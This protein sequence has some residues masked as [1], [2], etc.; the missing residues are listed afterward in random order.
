MHALNNYLG[1]PY[2]DQDACRRAA[3]AVVTALS[4]AGNGDVCRRAARAEVTALSGAGDGDAE[5][6]GNHIDPATGFLS[7][8]VINVLGAGVLGIHV[9]GDAVCWASLQTVE[10]GA[11]LVNWNNQHWTVLQTEPCSG[12]WIHTNSI[13]RGGPHHGR[14]RCD[15]VEDVEHILKRIEH[16]YGGVALHRIIRAVANVGPHYLESEG[17]RA[18]IDRDV[19]EGEGI[20]VREGGGVG[21]VA[22]T[23]ST[24]LSIITLNV[25]G[26]GVYEL[27]PTTRM[28]KMLAVILRSAADMILLQ[29]VVA[30]MYLVLQQRLPEWQIYRRRDVAEE[31]FNV[32]LVRTA[33]QST[34]DRTSS[35]AFPSSNNGRH[36]LTVRRDGWTVGN[37]HA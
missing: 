23:Q 13:C 9:E 37:V 18:M 25:D 20:I 14:V 4:G 2:V 28:E 21:H 19:D 3:R 7:I 35:Y 30:D 10:G 8:D 27:S 24:E 33:Q 22:C 6:L 16:D 12:V 36:M 1:G 11:A 5:S 26:L 34:E 29:E 15:S 32:T 17:L 31:Y